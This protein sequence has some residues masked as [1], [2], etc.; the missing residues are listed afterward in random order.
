MLIAKCVYRP[1]FIPVTDREL[2]PGLVIRVKVCILNAVFC[3]QAHPFDIMLLRH[4]ML[5]GADSYM[6]GISLNFVYG[7]VLLPGG[8]GCT[9]NQLLHGF[10]AAVDRN[11]LVPNYRNNVAAM[12]AN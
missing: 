5:R 10:T 1:N 4:G 11:T 6:N 7:D 2:C 3:F 9:G 12:P 8:F